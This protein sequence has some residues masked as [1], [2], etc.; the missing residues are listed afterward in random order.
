MIWATMIGFVIQELLKEVAA[1]E[2][3]ISTILKDG[4]AHRYKCVIINE[5]NSL[6][7][8][9]SGCLE[10]LPWKNTPRISG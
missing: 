4:L 9:C 7:K 3:V 2:Q 5:A 8:G 1:K 6:I 10:A